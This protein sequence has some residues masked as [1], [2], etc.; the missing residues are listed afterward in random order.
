MKKIIRIKES[1]LVN[2]ID[3][4]ITETTRKQKI[5]ENLTKIKYSKNKFI[6]EN[7]I[8]NKLYDK[9]SDLPVFDDLI[10]KIVSNMSAKD[11]EIFKSKFNINES[12]SVPSFEDIYSIVNQKNPENDSN[13][14]INEMIDK[15]SISG[16]VVNL[17]RNLTGLNLLAL[18]GLP[19]G[20]FINDVLN[21]G[22]YSLLGA[23]GPLI[24]LIASVIIHAISRK[25]LNVDSDEGIL[26]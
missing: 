24:S 22:T 15:K 20:L 19:L 23:V 11:I 1:E 21:I 16:K 13:L 4:I 3:K 9:I 18:G 8:I 25:L 7:T 2:L 17:I 14:T 6:N 10:N 26:G 12:M 5:T